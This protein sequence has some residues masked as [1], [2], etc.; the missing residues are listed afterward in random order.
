METL[1]NWNE[2]SE[3][4][5]KSI[6][7]FLPP[8]YYIWFYKFYT[9]FLGYFIFFGMIMA[10]ILMIIHNFFNIDLFDVIKGLFFLLFSIVLW[11]L[12]AYLIKHFYT[13]RYA[14]KIGLSIKNWNFLTAGMVF[15]K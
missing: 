14:K 7:S 1:K 6:N 4:Q 9:R 3:D 12:S 11:A 10:G 8:K 2:L 15:I 13:K 5:V